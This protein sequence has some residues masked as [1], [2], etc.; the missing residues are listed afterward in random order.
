[1]TVKDA[2]TVKLID[3][4]MVR[5]R[6]LAWQGYKQNFLDMATSLKNEIAKR[7]ARKHVSV[8]DTRHGA[9]FTCEEDLAFLQEFEKKKQQQAEVIIIISKVTHI[10]LTQT[11]ALTLGKRETCS[12]GRGKAWPD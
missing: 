4:K 12:C 6:E 2:Q 3:E 10:T 5:I 8:V 11:L 9:G 1:M 7:K